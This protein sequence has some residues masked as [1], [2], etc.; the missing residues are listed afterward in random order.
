M[1]IEVPETPFKRVWVDPELP[2]WLNTLQPLFRM[3][4]A[5]S[6]ERT[7]NLSLGSALGLPPL[8]VIHLPHVRAGLGDPTYKL[9]AIQ[10]FV[11]NQPF[12]W[13]DDDLDLFVHRWA[14]SRG[15]PTLLI[16]TRSAMGLH[17]GHFRELLDFGLRMAQERGDVS[18]IADARA[19]HEQRTTEI[20]PNEQTRSL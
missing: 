9:G 20:E 19:T 10:E 17:E 13:I 5:S 18:L 14:E 4:W 11:G 12:A 1:Y 3:I 2:S 15:V 16:H 7:G 8:P 6:W